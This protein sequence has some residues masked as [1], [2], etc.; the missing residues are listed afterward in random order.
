MRLLQCSVKCEV[1]EYRVRLKFIAIDFGIEVIAEEEDCAE[2][3]HEI[4]L[5]MHD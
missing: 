4:G 1:K 2:P 3:S 5:L